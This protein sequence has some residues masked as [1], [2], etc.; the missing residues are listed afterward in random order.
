MIENFINKYDCSFDISLLKYNT[1]KLDV[2]CKCL[3]FPKD[4]KELIDILKI[5]K[6]NNYKYYIL[7][8]GSNVIFKNDYYDGIIIK[9]DRF[10]KINIDKNIV[11]CDSG[12]SLMKLS[13]IAIKESLSGLEFAYGIPGLVGASV[14]MNAGAYKSELS[15]ILVSVKLL[16]KDLN[17]IEMRKE[18]LNFSYRNSFLKNNRDY[19]VLECTFKLFDG[20]KEEMM[21][22]VNK[23]RNRRL[24]TQPLEFPSAGSVFRNP[25]GMFAG[26]L[27]EKCNLKGYNINGAEVSEKHA[28]FIINKGGAKGEDIVKLINIIKDKVKDEFNIDLYLEQIIVD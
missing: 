21:E 24:L 14:A 5:I 28:N 22:K 1:Y 4:I 11:T 27:I 13:S 3:I 16:N 26:E 18:E 7:G 20:D 12:V 2:K 25:E 8:N 9:L 23:R 19:I 17:V 15:D 10:N 6:E